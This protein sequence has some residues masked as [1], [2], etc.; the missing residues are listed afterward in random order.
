MRKI[1][2]NNKV[3]VCEPLGLLVYIQMIGTCIYV[4]LYHECLV[5][6][7]VLNMHEVFSLLLQNEKLSSNFDDI[8]S[9][10]SCTPVPT[11][12]DTDAVTLYDEYFPI[13]H[14]LSI[15]SVVRESLATTDIT[16]EDILEHLNRIKSSEFDQQDSGIG[17]CSGEQINHDYG[18]GFSGKSYSSYVHCGQ[19]NCVC[20]SCLVSRAEGK[21]PTSM[22]LFSVTEGNSPT[23]P[24]TIC[25]KEDIFVC[26]TTLSKSL[27]KLSSCDNHVTTNSSLSISSEIV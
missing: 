3:C 19:Y 18:S 21:S 14:T 5:H 24:E 4:K 9:I 23:P 13:G 10:G 20:N 27:P 6:Y 2:L 12:A 7:S 17:E 15:G 8:L 1:G 11:D 26:I 25:N 22:G 16:Y